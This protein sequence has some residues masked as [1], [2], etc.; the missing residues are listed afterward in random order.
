MSDRGLSR[1]VALFLTAALAVAAFQCVPYV[2][3]PPR[4]PPTGLAELTQEQKE[5]FCQQGNYS[6]GRPLICID[7]DTLQP[8]PQPA[9]VWD[10]EG[11]NGNPTNTPVVIHWFTQRTANLGISFAPGSNCVGEVHCNGRGRCI[12]VV[13]PL[14]EGEEQRQCKYDVIVD[15]K[16]NDPDLIVNPCCS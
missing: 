6:K 12:A 1:R 3:S 5:T 9:P 4:L 2:D 14:G 15:G 11:F 8:H 13:Q 16:R 10:Y 7:N